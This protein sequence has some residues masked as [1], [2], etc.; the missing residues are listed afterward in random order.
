VTVLLYLYYKYFPQISYLGIM[1]SDLWQSWLADET[2]V[3]W[4]HKRWPLNLRLLLSRTW[5]L[6]QLPAPPQPQVVQPH[7]TKP[8]TIHSLW[9]IVTWSPPN[10]TGP[11]TFYSG[12][13][14]PLTTA[15]VDITYIKVKQDAVLSR[16]VSL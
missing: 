16:G 8:T 1:E 15:Y 12:H 3:I 11:V 5:I 6:T 2:V 9:V 10:C 7:P 13:S 4:R 14:R